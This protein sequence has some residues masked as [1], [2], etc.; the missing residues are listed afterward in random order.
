MMNHNTKEIFQAFELR[1]KMPQIRPAIRGLYEGEINWGAYHYPLEYDYGNSFYSWKYG[2]VHNI[3]L[4]PYTR[5]DPDS[6]QYQW[7]IQALE[8]VDRTVTPWLL[9]S[10]HVPLYNTFNDHHRDDNNDQI[11]EGFPV[12]PLWK[13][14]DQAAKTGD[15]KQHD[16]Q[17]PQGGSAK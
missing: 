5:M 9:V 7:L 2:G 11:G 16:R 3:M 12:R 1:F 6:R 4:N 10:I 15:A 17:S 14:L 8:Q 13:Q